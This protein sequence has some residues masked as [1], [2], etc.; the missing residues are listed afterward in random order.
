MTRIITPIAGAALAQ[1]SRANISMTRII[2][3]SPGVAV[4]Q[5]LPGEVKALV[6]PPVA[7]YPDPSLVAAGV[8][9]GP[10]GQEFTGTFVGQAGSSFTV[11]E[12]VNAIWSSPYAMTVAKYQA[13]K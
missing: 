13:M 7:V 11:D 12:V 3:A 8:K 10:T 6:L 9:Y 2:S 4:A 1:G 5:G